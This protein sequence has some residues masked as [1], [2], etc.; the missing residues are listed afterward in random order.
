MTIL[1]VPVFNYRVPGEQDGLS[2]SDKQ[3]IVNADH[4]IRDR[5]AI[6]IAPNLGTDLDKG[7]ILGVTT[8]DSLFRPVRR[9]P[10]TAAAASGATSLQVAAAAVLNVGDTVSVMKA[11]GSGVEAVGTV[12]SVTVA[13]GNATVVVSTATAE[14]LVIGDFLYVS[15]GSQ[16]ALVVLADVVLD[17]TQNKVASAYVAG[18]FF[19]SKLVGLDSIAIT[20]LKARLI[21]YGNDPVT[22]TADSILIV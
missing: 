20:D 8:A 19:Q 7:T 17:A 3:I 16:K 1:S 21:P 18:K 9:Y 5:L 4:H 10:L 14:A 2:Y 15:D 6:T 12:S 22:N 11:D 13:G